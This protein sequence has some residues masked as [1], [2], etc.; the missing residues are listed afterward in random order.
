MYESKWR[1]DERKRNNKNWLFDVAQQYN[2]EVTKVRISSF[3]NKIMCEKSM[4]TE[5]P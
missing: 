5:E 1:M 3:S 2:D 4:Q